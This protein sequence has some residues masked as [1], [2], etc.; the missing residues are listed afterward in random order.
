MLSGQACEYP[1]VRYVSKGCIIRK[2]LG[3][4]KKKFSVFK[5][6]EKANVARI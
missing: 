5:N 4:G 2:G 3:L 6:R 1:G